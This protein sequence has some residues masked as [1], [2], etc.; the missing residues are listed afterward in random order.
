VSGKKKKKKPLTPLP[1]TQKKKER[2]RLFS[3]MAKSTSLS[4]PPF[5]SQS[6]RE[7][8]K[9]PRSSNHTGSPTR[10]GNRK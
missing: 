6:L 10:T 5:L 8:E 9:R 3:P 2:D 1:H 4:Q 7:K